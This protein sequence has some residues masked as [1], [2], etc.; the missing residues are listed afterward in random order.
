MNKAIRTNARGEIDKNRYDPASGLANSL[1]KSIPG[2]P[3]DPASTRGTFLLRIADGLKDGTISINEA[4]EA[5]EEAG[6][7]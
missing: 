3:R 6:T 2:D 7:C 1:L 5:N 4:E